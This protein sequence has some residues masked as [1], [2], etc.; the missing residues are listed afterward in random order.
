M[1]QFGVKVAPRDHPKVCFSSLGSLWIASLG[2]E[3]ALTLFSFAKLKDDAKLIEHWYIAVGK[4]DPLDGDSW[5]KYIE[6]SGLRQLRQVISLDH[7]LCPP[8]IEDLVDSDWKYNVQADFLT[9]FFKDLDYLLNRIPSGGRFNLLAVLL[10]PTL[11]V[12]DSLDDP[13]FIFC[14][15]DLVEMDSGIS[16]LTNCGGFEVAFDNA[17]LSAE[18][19]I[20]TFARAQEIQSALLANYPDEPHSDC[21]IWAIWCMDDAG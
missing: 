11:E 12:G 1:P 16:S 7:V 15:Y 2:C 18:G 14:G 3:W 20:E 5:T 19:L 10:S 6:W 17:E 21:D 13:R 4:F 8:L 9:H